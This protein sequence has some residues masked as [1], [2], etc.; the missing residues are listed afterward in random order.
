MATYYGF[1]MIEGLENNTAS[2]FKGSVRPDELG[3]ESRLND[4]SS[5]FSKHSQTRF[6]MRRSASGT[7]TP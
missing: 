2:F 5:F 6:A 3:V 1:I 7:G 4:E